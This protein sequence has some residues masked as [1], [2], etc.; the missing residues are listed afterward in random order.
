MLAT[1]RS[2][3]QTPERALDIQN[4][5]SE[6]SGK[7]ALRLRGYLVLAISD[8]VCLAIAFIGT[9]LLYM[10]D[11]QSPHGWVILLCILPIYLVLAAYNNAYSG[12]V[13]ANPRTG[14]V[15]A[16]QSF[17]WSAAVV[18]FL[19]YFLKAGSNFSR[20]VFAMGSIASIGLIAT[21]RTFVGSA[22]LRYLGGTPFTTVVLVDGVEYVPQGSE[23]IIS[24]EQIGFDPRTSDPYHYHLFAAAVREADRLI[25]ACS[26][27][28][29]PLWSAVL[30]S[31]SVDG[32]ILTDEHDSLGI[33]GIDSYND[34]QTLVVSVEPLHL[35]QRI[36]KRM[37]DIA[38]SSAALLLLSPLLI[39]VAIAIRLDSAGP[40][41]F[42][43]DRI[44]RDNRIFSMFKFRS[45]YVDQC[46]SNAVQLT[47]RGDR[48]VTRVGA[49]IRAYSLDELPQLLNVLNGTMSIVGPR[50][51][52]IS[53]KAG[54]LLYWDVDNRYRFRHSI[55]PGLTGLAQIR[56]F[57]GATERTEDLTN[58]LTADLEYLS[59][60]SIS[61]D[62]WIILQTFGVL[63]H[64]NAF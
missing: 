30:K 44:G 8:A 45:M 56:G 28:R 6:Q 11:W 53:A 38:F 3:K 49:F 58:R 46:D 52:A 20:I 14:I 37:F 64:S 4:L 15:Y 2:G 51:H 59:R 39:G 23:R 21:V 22:L 48:R 13:L 54:D 63:R 1:N 12:A 9:S 34:R 61:R 62:I 55:K 5:Q 7:E 60:W 25:V 19:A 57:R 43:Q 31:L 47:R 27:A 26:Q 41:F 17:L 33:L 32:E 36:V 10:K 50:P 35:R 16:A 40:I 42:R 18:L 24:A 29:Y